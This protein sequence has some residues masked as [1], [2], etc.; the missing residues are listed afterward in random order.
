MICSIFSGSHD[1]RNSAMLVVELFNGIRKLA[2]AKIV[3]GG[4][5]LM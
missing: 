2:A 4:K 5:L 3:P 1:L